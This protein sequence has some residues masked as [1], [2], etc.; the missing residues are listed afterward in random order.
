MKLQGRSRTIRL[1]TLLGGL[2]FP[3]MVFASLANARPELE[4]SPDQFD[5]GAVAPNATV[6]FTGWLHSVGDDTL[7]IESVKTGCGCT[8]VEQLPEFLPPG[9]S[10]QLVVDWQTR[11]AVGELSTRVYL[12]TSAQSTPLTLDLQAVGGTAGYPP[13]IFLG[14]PERPK[15]TAHNLVLRSE[16]DEDLA[17]EVLAGADEAFEFVLPDTLP[18]NDVAVGRVWLADAY[19]DGPFERSVTLA[20]SRDGEVRSRLTIPVAFGDFSFRPKFTTETIVSESTTEVVDP[21]RNER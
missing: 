14:T 1:C 2:L 6:R 17:I 8:Q 19:N 12:F 20:L 15:E 16:S 13:A 21:R 4:M 11:A 5:F 10:A 7:R 9:D 18:A 3:L